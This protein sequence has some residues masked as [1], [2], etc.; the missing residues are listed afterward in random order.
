MLFIGKVLCEDLCY[1]TLPQ[2]CQPT[3]A[4]TT[5]PEVTTPLPT[6]TPEVTTPLPTTTPE[7][8]R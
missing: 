7:V 6:T 8:T 1:D 4:P 2:R 3:Q 5:T